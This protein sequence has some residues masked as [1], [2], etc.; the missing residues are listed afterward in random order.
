MATPGLQTLSAPRFERILNELPFL[1]MLRADE[2]AVCA[3]F[4]NRETLAPGSER[5]LGV[6]GPELCVVLRGEVAIEAAPL[7]G[8]PSQV[9]QVRSGDCFGEVALAAG[10]PLRATLRVSEQGE[11]AEIAR[12][13]ASGLALLLEAFPAAALPLCQEIADEVRFK[14]GLIRELGEVEA[15]RL[16]GTDL[17]GALAA[18]R[19]QLRR[20]GTGVVRRA[21]SATYQELVYGRGREPAFWMLLGFLG[22]L[23]G[24]RLMVGFILKF[25]LE[26][27]F[28]ALTRSR[29]YSNPMHLHHFN[30]G[31]VLICVA[32]LAA[33]LPRSRRYART[34]AALFGIGSGLICDEWALIW[35]L[36]PNY[37]QPLS[38]L[39]VLFF[40]AI[41]LQLVLFRGFWSAWLQRWAWRWSS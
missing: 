6:E 26:A 3:R 14:D 30:Y 36:D 33:F 9:S 37:Y 8:Q 22:A 24:A 40:G 10:R 39:A 25:H 16:S 20:H 27:Q 29:E 17:S 18:R 28:F 2:L 35:N 31:L 15:L 21:A 38:Y 13:G 1:S 5:S 32:G 41:L 19:R 34:F 4:F 7:P 12:L 23:L 11:R